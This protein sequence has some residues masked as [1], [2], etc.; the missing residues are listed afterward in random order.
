MGDGA[1]S[2]VLAFANVAASVVVGVAASQ[3]GP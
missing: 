2:L 1:A 3:P